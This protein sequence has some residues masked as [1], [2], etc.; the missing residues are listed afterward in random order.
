MKITIEPTIKVD[1]DAFLSKPW[2]V[3]ID[4]GDDDAT[5]DE[6]VAICAKALIAYGYHHDNITAT[7]NE[8][9][10]KEVFGSIK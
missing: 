9:F 5:A 4:T 2:S 6:A 1:C 3:V 8:E 7:L 10:V